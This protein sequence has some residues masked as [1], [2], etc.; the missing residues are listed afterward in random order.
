MSVEKMTVRNVTDTAD[1][2]VFVYVENR[3]SRGSCDGELTPD[4]ARAF[5]D[6]LRAAA[7]RA[8]QRRDS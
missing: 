7:D 3:D 4:E 1:G 8:E 2:T 5:A 6:R